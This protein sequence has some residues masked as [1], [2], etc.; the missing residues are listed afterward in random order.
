MKIAGPTEN[1]RSPQIHSSEIRNLTMPAR[2]TALGWASAP[3][4]KPAF[5][6]MRQAWRHNLARKAAI[7]S[8]VTVPVG[9]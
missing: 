6:S 5:A 3:P 7:C 2:T 8:R 4:C 1:P 9:S